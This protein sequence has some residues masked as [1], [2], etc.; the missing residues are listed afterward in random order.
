[1][2]LIVAA[3]LGTGGVLHAVMKNRQVVVAREIDDDLLPLVVEQAERVES[4]LNADVSFGCQHDRIFVRKQ[5]FQQQSRYGQEDLFPFTEELARQRL[6]KLR[7]ED[8]LTNSIRETILKQLPFGLPKIKDTAGR[9]NMTS[10]TLQRRLQERN[11]K[12]QTL[13]DEVRRELSRQLI[14]KP[15]LSLS[16]IAD[17]LGFSDQS[18]FQ[19]AFARWENTT[20]GRFRSGL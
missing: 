19:H 7:G 16:E 11:V 1:M 12:Y 15:E 13:L 8:P 3:L 20:P 5:F 9:L 10:R 6:M 4:A 14:V 17:Y 18:A 2:I